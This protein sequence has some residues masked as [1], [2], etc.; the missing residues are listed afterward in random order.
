VDAGAM[1]DGYDVISCSCRQRFYEGVFP[2]AGKS[3]EFHGYPE[4]GALI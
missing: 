2:H 4:S 3:L 1:V